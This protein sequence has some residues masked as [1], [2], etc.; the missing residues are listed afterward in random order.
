MRGAAAL[1]VL[2][3]AIAG[4]GDDSGG[5][6]TS[7]KPSSGARNDEAIRQAEEADDSQAQ[8]GAAAIR[9]TLRAKLNLNAGNE[10]DLDHRI[11]SG[12]V[13]SDCYVKLGAE[14]V[15]FE[16]QTE[17]ILYAPNGKD[18][19]FVQSSTETPLVRCLKEVRSA[20]GW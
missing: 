20:L 19:V 15:S 18:L 7:S 10:F 16:D 4:C 5:R 14:A 17:N 12:Q 2:V 8:I 9:K 1:V 11:D 6:P 3:I 13:G